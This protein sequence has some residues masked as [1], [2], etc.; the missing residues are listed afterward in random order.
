M[1][2]EDELRRFHT[3]GALP[4]NQEPFQ[5]IDASPQQDIG[6]EFSF[7]PKKSLVRGYSFGVDLRLFG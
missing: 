5:E 1:K 3:A 4:T 6:S 7:G 2:T